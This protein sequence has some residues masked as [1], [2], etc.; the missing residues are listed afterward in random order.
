MHTQRRQRIS[1]I[2]TFFL[3]LILNVLIKLKL[4]KIKRKAPASPR[5]RFDSTLIMVDLVLV[6]YKQCK[7][8]CAWVPTVST[9]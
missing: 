9:P 6:Y 2:P 7:V 4:S 8:K 3:I 1:V 5:R